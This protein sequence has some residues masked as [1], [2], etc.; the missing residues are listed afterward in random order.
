MDLIVCNKC[1]HKKPLEDYP[2]NKNYKSGFSPF[3]K[4]CKN[5]YYKTYLNNKKTGSD[6]KTR[7]YFEYKLFNLKEQDLKRFPDYESTLTVDDL[8]AIYMKY[9]KTCVYS[10]KQLKPGSRVNI[11]AKVSFDRIDNALP[12]TKENLQLTSVFMNML[13]GELTSER[14]DKIIKEYDI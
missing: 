10:R 4:E 8:M 5:T 11:Y 1:F 6:A 9:D 13:R 7:K 3:C 12:H 2:R 14:F